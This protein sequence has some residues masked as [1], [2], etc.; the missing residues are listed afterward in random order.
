MSCKGL[1]CD[2]CGG[3]GGAITAIA[4][5]GFLGV[6]IYHARRGV[7]TGLEIGVCVLAGLVVLAVGVLIA[8]WRLRRSARF[9]AGSAL[10]AHSPGYLDARQAEAISAPARRPALDA[11]GQHVHLHFDGMNPAE[12]AAIIARMNNRERG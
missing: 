8:Y 7:E 10:V 3:A 12:V 6:F 4:V 11:A 1:H 5:V 2:G 9:R